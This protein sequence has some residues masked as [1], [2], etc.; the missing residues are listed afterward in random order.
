MRRTNDPRPTNSVEKD[1]DLH[2]DEL[3]GTADTDEE[4]S[5][6]ELKDAQVEAK[7]HR[8][9]LDDKEVEDLF[10]DADEEGFEESSLT[11]GYFIIF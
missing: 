7:A 2:K 4:V 6:D 5:E 8:E 1:F 3:I 10:G 11:K 9:E